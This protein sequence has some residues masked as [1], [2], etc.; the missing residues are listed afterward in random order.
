MSGGTAAVPVHCRWDFCTETF[1]TFLEWETH[2]MVEHIA[3]ARPIDLAGRRLVKRKE[4]GQWELVDTAPRPISILPL[5]PHPSQTTGD[6]TTTT[7]TLSFPMP[8]SF[9]SLPDPPPTMPVALPSGNQGLLGIES[10]PSDKHAQD[11][12][13]DKRLYQSFLRSPSPVP[14]Q[15][16]SISQSGSTSGSMQPPPPGQRSKTPPWTPRHTHPSVTSPHILHSA[17]DF[18]TANPTPPVTQPTSSVP[19]FTSPFR[20]SQEYAQ[21]HS[22]PD[23]SGS[24]ASDH[25]L[26]QRADSAGSTAGT[27]IR[28]GA[29]LVGGETSSL[30]GESPSRSGSKSGGGVGFDWA[31]GT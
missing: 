18:D 2:F 16:R 17:P 13:N 30:Y 25:S 6:I 15:S 23:H 24:S 10:N 20:P 26:R 8:P 19:L 21:S 27:N 29:V 9:H 4:Q 12:E 1:L 5:N 22:T 3:Y 7:H 14:G 31:G 11:E 28:F